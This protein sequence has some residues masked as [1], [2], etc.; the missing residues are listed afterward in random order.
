MAPVMTLV[1]HLIFAGRPW[2]GLAAPLCYLD[3][4]AL[5]H[6]NASPHAKGT[7]PLTLTSE[8]R[9]SAKLMR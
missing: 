5:N 9:P 2:Q 7:V 6:P 4:F 1:L 8:P 3:T